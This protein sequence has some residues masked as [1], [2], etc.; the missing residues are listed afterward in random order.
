VTLTPYATTAQLILNESLGA[1]ARGE[2]WPVWGTCLG[3]ELLL[4]LAAGPNGA[5]LGQGFDS[6]DLQL[7]LAPA[8]S[9]ASSRLWGTIAAEEPAAWTWLTSENITEN[10]HVQG[11]E[12]SA[13][14][15]NAALAAS[16]ALLT[17]NVDRKGRSFVSSFEGKLA[18]VYGSQFHPEKPAWEWTADYAIPHTYHAVT[19]NNALARFLVNE[20]RRNSRAFASRAAMLAALLGNTAPFFTA[21]L[22]DAT[23]RKWEAVY[24]FAPWTAPNGG[25]G[26]AAD[27]LSANV[28]GGA[29]GGALAL[30][31]A[32]AAGS[33]WCRAAKREN[34]ERLLA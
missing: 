30:V 22:E 5:V 29:A 18:P 7:A 8:P 27:G 20:A 31:A 12:P 25:S 15:A 21:G 4:V 2:W 23:L 13:F 9:A 19:A 3:H 10:L 32:A 28:I 16:Y 26:S 24:V 11:V 34:G 14:A 1:A 6:E 33:A 17:T